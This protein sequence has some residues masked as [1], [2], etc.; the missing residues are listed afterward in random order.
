MIFDSPQMVSLHEKY[1]NLPDYEV[2]DIVFLDRYDG[3]QGERALL[4][5]LL[6]SVSTNKQRDWFGRLV[7]EESQQHIG[8]W[9]EIMLYG[10]FRESFVVHVEPEVIGNYPDFVLDI[11]GNQ[12]A[13]EARAFLIPP[14]ERERKQKFDRIFS[15]LSSIQKPFLVSLKIKQ[16]GEK[17]N[18]S[19]FVELV[20]LWLDST[21]EQEFNYRDNVGNI[22]RLSATPGPT[23]KKVGVISTEMLRVNPDVLKAPLHEK[24]KQH[25]AL[26]KAGYPYVIAIFLEPSHLSAEE[27]SEAWLGKTIVVLDVDTNQVAEEKLDQSGI[28][29]WGNEIRHKSVSGTLVF[30]TGYDEV[31]K[32]R[33]L[34]SWYVQNP[35]ANVIIDPALFP[36]ESRFVVVRQDEKLYEMKWVR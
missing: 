7:N 23:L 28:H 19:E 12:L 30:K 35:Y 6:K 27:V 26:R 21:A 33:Y 25:R 2:P 34:Q 18:I 4:E 14:E 32:S 15:S 13:I 5:D 17:I 31:R 10:W 11:Q 36:V 1:R 24:A 16:L 29:F 8:T 22:L 20:N 9:F 3:Y